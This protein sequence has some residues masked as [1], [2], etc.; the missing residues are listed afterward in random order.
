MFQARLALH[1]ENDDQI[2]RFT[3]RK[4]FFEAG[5]GFI[6][7]RLASARK[8]TANIDLFDLSPSQ[9]CNTTWQTGCA[10]QC[11]VVNNYGNAVASEANIKLDSV[12]A[13]RDRLAESSH[14]VFRC[15]RRRTAMTDD[16][17]CLH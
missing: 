12:A 4:Q 1:L 7:K 13:C 5:N 16:Q 9:I 17:R 6:L 2:V 14:R 8:P 15:Y 3:K 10:P 11:I